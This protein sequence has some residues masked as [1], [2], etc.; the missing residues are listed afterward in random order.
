MRKLMFLA[1]LPVALY[2]CSTNAVT[3]RSQLSLIPEAELQTMAAQEY[4]TFLTQNKVVTS[5][6]NKDAEMV[7]R[8]GQR[9]TNAITQYYTSKGQANLLDGYQWEYNL[10]DSKDVNAWCMPGGKIVVYTGL[11]PIT[12]NEA[13]LAVVVG[14]EVTHALAKHGNERMSQGMIQQLGGVALGVA[15]AN[16]SQETHNLFMNAYGIGSN[17]LV[18]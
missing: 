16:K 9:I 13:A 7:R 4:R 14:H 6:A 3:G 18:P 8:V 1:L 12:Q 5:T 15:L 10:V 2:S 17:V 11:L